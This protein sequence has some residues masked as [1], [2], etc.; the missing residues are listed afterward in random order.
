M[1]RTGQLD[2]RIDFKREVPYV[3][4]NGDKATTITSIRDKVWSSIKFV[5]TPSAG[6]SE[7]RIDDEQITGKIKIEVTCRYFSGVTFQSYFIYENRIFE[8]YSILVLGKK[9]WLQVRGQLRDDQSS[10]FS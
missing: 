6:A 3:D 4:S 5:G 9:E 7:E 10:I 8:I 1:R 2:H